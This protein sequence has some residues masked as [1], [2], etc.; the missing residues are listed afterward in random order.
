MKWLRLYHDTIT[1]PKWRLVAN[2]SGQPVG[3]VLA[4]WMSML[5]N[6]SD[7]SERGTLEGW[8]DRYVAANLGYPTDAVRAIREAMQGVVLDGDRLTGWDGRQ[9]ASDDAGGRQRKTRERRGTKPPGG[10]GHGGNGHDPEHSATTT[11]CRATFP[12]CPATVAENPLRAQTPDTESKK[13]T[14]AYASGAAA[15]SGGTVVSFPMDDKSRLFGPVLALLIAALP[16]RKP[17]DVRAKVAKAYHALGVEEALDLTARAAVKDEPWSWFCK[18]IDARTKPKPAAGGRPMTSDDAAAHD[19][20]T[21][22]RANGYL[23]GDP[24]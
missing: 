4:V 24:R 2:E 7:S 22:L 3:D 19:L 10:G 5:I 12:D 11:E 20:L 21:D 15:P 9:R 6:A 13:D 23:L 16:G 1:D 17:D 18:A 14:E 8:Q